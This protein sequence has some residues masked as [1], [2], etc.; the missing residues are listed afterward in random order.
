MTFLLVLTLLFGAAFIIYAW[1][2]RSIPGAD[3]FILLSA[4]IA[5]VNATYIGELNSNQ[6]ADA[7][8]WSYLDHLV[9]PLT[10]YFWLMLCLDY[11]QIRKHRRLIQTASCVYIAFYYFVF[12][13][14]KYLHL[15]IT[16][17]HF[18]S[19]GY[20]PVIVSEKGWGFIAVLAMITVMGAAC[21]LIYIDGL[22]KS[23]HMH[24]SGYLLMMIAS[25][26]P[27]LSIY[28]NV[29][30]NTYLGVDYYS[31][32]MVFTG[33]LYLFGLFRYHLFST[34]P[35]ATETV[36]RLS[37]D[38]IALADI[39]G[40]I[41]D[42]NESFLRSYPELKRLRKK[43]T[44]DDFLRYH[45]ELAGLSLQG[46]EVN[47][48]LCG[49]DGTKQYYLAKLTPIFSENGMRIGQILSIKDVTVYVEYENQL[50]AI[51]RNAMRLAETNELS[52]LQAQISPHFINNTLSAISSLIE[53]D[54]EKARGLVVSLSEYLISCYRENT[55]PM[56]A[57]RHELEAVDTYMQI[58]QARMGGRIRYTAEIGKLPEFEIPRLVLQPLVENAVRHGLQPKKAG[59]TVRLSI[60]RKASYAFFEIRDDGVGIQPERIATL[61]S[62]ID[63]RQ[64]VGIINIHKRLLRYYGEGLSISS[65]GGTSVKFRIPVP[66]GG[67]KGV[68]TDD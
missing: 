40:R 47:F 49:N 6:L 15:Y 25:I 22:L 34:I 41:T 59:G 30:Q 18:V 50:K 29:R 48:H 53:R 52:F 13:T 28:F 10:P 61:L 44:L 42:T 57:L 8:V 26:I 45:K 16:S 1:K 68:D 5:F 17:Y 2:R 12:F 64:G 32:T 24:R 66:D 3:Y 63:D 35:I 56:A 65:D 20:F 36:Y 51:A 7:L 21:T 39:S 11:S 43:D 55:S 33:A 31:F 58:V 37:Q 4:S 67:L 46:G 54:P 38:A 62:G 9:L 19:N 60:R 14:N 27:W 23:S